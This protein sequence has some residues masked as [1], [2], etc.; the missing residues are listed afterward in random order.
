M[1]AIAG[2]ALGHAFDANA[3]PYYPQQQARLS[4]GEETQFTFFVAAFSMLAKLVRTDGRISTAEINSIEE[5]MTQDL[6]L[7]PEADGLRS[8]SS[9]PP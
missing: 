7:S 1:G 9:T 5:F 6:N 4:S 3:D 2:A 8:T